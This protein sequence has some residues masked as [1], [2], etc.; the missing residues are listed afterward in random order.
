LKL[1]THCRD[2]GDYPQYVVR[3]YPVYRMFNVLTPR[4]FRA[5]LADVKY[6]DAASRKT[7]ETRTGLFLEGR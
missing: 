1:G 6:V 7:I 4:S 3:E 5:R 2:Q